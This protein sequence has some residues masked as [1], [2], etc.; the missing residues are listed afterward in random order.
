MTYR[1]GWM[2]VAAEVAI[3]KREVCGDK[4]FGVLRRAKNGTVVTDSQ[5][6]VFLIGVEIA[7]YLF[8]EREF[9][10]ELGKFFHAK[11]QDTCG[12]IVELLW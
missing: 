1:L 3:F 5:R 7:S 8:D 4:D 11:V 2:E 12:E 6:E 9:S 10:G